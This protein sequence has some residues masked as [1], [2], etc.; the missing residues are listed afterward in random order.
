MNIS[1]D[2][3]DLGTCRNKVYTVLIFTQSLV[4]FHWLN[5]DKFIFYKGVLKLMP[6][7]FDLWD[8]NYK[9]KQKKT[10]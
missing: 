1:W 4:E 2:M 7:L 6:N 5:F 10:T 3:T 8:E 9:K